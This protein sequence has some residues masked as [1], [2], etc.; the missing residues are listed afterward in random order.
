MQ[1]GG[2][3]H[4]VVPDDDGTMALSIPMLHAWEGNKLCRTRAHR[5]V[6]REGRTKGQTAGWYDGV[7]A[8]Y[9]TSMNEGRCG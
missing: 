1:G 2:S 4:A 5:D 8:R 3:V 9:S 6:V 7:C